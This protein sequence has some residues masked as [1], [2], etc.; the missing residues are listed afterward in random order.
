MFQNDLANAIGAD[1]STRKL[2]WRM[3]SSWGGSF[4]SEYGRERKRQVDGERK[5]SF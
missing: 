2:W 1:E 3:R 5:K 4:L